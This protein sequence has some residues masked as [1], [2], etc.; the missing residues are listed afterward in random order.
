MQPTIYS[1]PSLPYPE[2]KRVCNSVHI[3]T[4]EKQLQFGMHFPPQDRRKDFA[5]CICCLKTHHNRRT[6]RSLGK[7]EIPKML[8]KLLWNNYFFTALMGRILTETLAPLERPMF[9]STFSPAAFQ[10]ISSAV[11]SHAVQG[12]RMSRLKLVADPGILFSCRF[13]FHS[14]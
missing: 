6:W 9:P 10:L 8:V 2:E 4:A 1:L 7:K 12:S 5:G 14:L 3:W 13:N 11:S